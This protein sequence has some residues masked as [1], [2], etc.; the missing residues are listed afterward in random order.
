MKHAGL[1]FFL[2]LLIS[3]GVTHTIYD[4]DEQQDFSI[5]KTYAFYPE[6]NSG[7]NDLD[8]KRL[9]MVTETVMKSKGFTKSETPDIH[10]NFK[11]I[12]N[13]TPSRNSIGVGVGSGSGGVSIGVGGSIPIGGP[14]TF[15]ELTIDFVDVKK[16]EL[17]WQAIAERRFYPNASPDV[18]TNFFQK[19]IEKS[20]VKYPPKNKE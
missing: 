3:C 7:L 8:Q 12:M 2:V 13:K 6:M 10:M 9:L 5:Y 20:L 17:V 15:L 4:Y 16:D 11:A 18:R 1:F 14:E 19:I